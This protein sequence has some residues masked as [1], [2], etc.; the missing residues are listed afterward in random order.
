MSFFLLS[1]K[2]TLINKSSKSKTEMSCSKVFI[3]V[4][5][6]KYQL[7]LVSLTLETLKKQLLEVTKDDNNSNEKE[8]ISIKITDVNSCAIETDEHLQQ[9]IQNS[10]FHFIGYFQQQSINELQLSE[11]TLTSIPQHNDKNS[12]KEMKEDTPETLDFKK[13]WNM[14]WVK[15]NAKAAIMVEEMK[16][17]NK[18]GLIMVITNKISDEILNNEIANYKTF[19]DYRLYVIEQKV[20]KILNEIN[21]NGNMYA[22]DCEIQC[23]HNINISTQLFVTDNVIV[24]YHFIPSISPIIWNSKFHHDIPVELQNYFDSTNAFRT[25]NAIYCAQKALELCLNN[26]KYIHPYVANAYS[27]LGIAYRANC[28]Y[29]KARDCYEKALDISFNIFGNNHGWMAN[30]YSSYGTTYYNNNEYNEAIEYY[31]KSLEIR[32]NIF[33][34]NHINVA[35]FYATLANTYRE[36]EEI[37]KAIECSEKE[38]HILLNLFG[39]KDKDVNNVYKELGS[40]FRQIGKNKEACKYFEESWRICTCYLVNFMQKQENQKKKY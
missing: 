27:N 23:Q 35:R 32:L 37:D 11:L 24:D 14:D 34:I 30:L 7:E 16:N 39:Y 13:H 8:D 31:S 26:F 6:N 3:S 2:I 36:N 33:G 18:Q 1:S 20:I 5:T 10:Q 21:I 4:G 38:L 12:L 17:Q 19:G 28:E 15:S 22:I 9:A 40:M 29:S 25:N